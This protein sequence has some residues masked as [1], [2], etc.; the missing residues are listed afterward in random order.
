M[1]EDGVEVEGGREAEVEFVGEEGSAVAE[2]VVALAEGLE[3]EFRVGKREAEERVWRLGGH[4]SWGLG[5]RRTKADSPSHPLRL[6]R[7]SSACEST[8][9]SAYLSTTDS[10]ISDAI[11]TASSL[12]STSF[13]FTLTTSSR[14]HRVQRTRS[15]PWQTQPRLAHSISLTRSGL[16]VQS[17]S[18]W[19]VARRRSSW[20][21]SPGQ[22]LGG[23]GW[24]SLAS[25]AGL[26]APPGVHLR[27]VT[28]EMVVDGTLRM[29]AGE[30]RIGVVCCSA[31]YLVGVAAGPPTRRFLWRSWVLSLAMVRRLERSSDE[32]CDAGEDAG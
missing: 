1:G 6:H 15:L 28:L 23:G 27:S 14:A 10:A 11:S 18:S 16:G 30:D 5:R 29:L 8:I 12:P 26:A 13:R 31:V 21:R 4:V 2:L 24:P 19:K 17:V 25:G 20:S 22:Y 3:G 32:R 9:S 7:Q